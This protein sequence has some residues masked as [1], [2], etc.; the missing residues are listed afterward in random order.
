MLVEPDGFARLVLLRHPELAG[1]YATRA[2]GQDD[3]ELSRRGRRQTIEVARFLA[4]LRID[5]VFSSPAAH[6]VATADALAQGRGLSAETDARLHDQGLG[7]WQ[8]RQWS[9]LHLTEQALV[10]QFFAD[11]GMVA[12]PDG[13]TL[14]G[15]VDR[16]LEW[17][18]ETCEQMMD[19][20]S[21]LVGSAPLLSGLAAR[22]LGL[23]LRRAPALSLP[24]AALGILDVY[25][26][27]AVLRSWHPLCLS[28]ELP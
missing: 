9:E 4:P 16:A 15:A 7:R 10:R 1:P 12:P 13:E 17:W 27:G 25:R 23:S 11:Y 28:D 14:G 5:R 21:L 2:L 18:N 26:D 3:A 24:R 19:R 20:T 8:G 22:L 6:A